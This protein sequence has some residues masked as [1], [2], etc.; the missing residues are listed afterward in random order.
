VSALTFPKLTFRLVGGW[1]IDVLEEGGRS[2]MALRLNDFWKSRTT[3]NLCSVLRD[4]LWG[5]LD[6]EE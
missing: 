3:G 4:I 6:G 2:T 1:V 5:H